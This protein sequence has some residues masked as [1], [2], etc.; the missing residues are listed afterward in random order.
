MSYI[1]VPLWFENGNGPASTADDVFDRLG[2][3]RNVMAEIYAHDGK[4]DSLQFVCFSFIIF[5]IINFIFIII[6]II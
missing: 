6:V 1:Q 2:R 4:V 3:V 5:L